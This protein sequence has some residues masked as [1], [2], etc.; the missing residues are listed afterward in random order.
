MTTLQDEAAL[1][2]ERLLQLDMLCVEELIR[3][4]AERRRLMGVFQNAC[5]YNFEVACRNWRYPWHETLPFSYINMHGLR[6]TMHT[7]NGREME[8]GEF[9]TW[10]HGRIECAPPLPPQII[11]V[12]LDATNREIAVLTQHS[13]DVYDYAPGGKMYRALCQTTLVGKPIS[14]QCVECD[15]S[16]DGSREGGAPRGRH[17]GRL[18]VRRG[19]RRKRRGVDG[20]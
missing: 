3:L 17:T 10:Y 4:K 16:D 20:V 2:F 8:C 11:K 12:E 1:A 19:S 7:R 13:K 14:E 18:G 5:W 6:I 15:V 9:P